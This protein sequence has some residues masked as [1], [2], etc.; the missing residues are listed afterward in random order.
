MKLTLQQVPLAYVNQTW[1][2]VEEFIQS[3]FAE[4]DPG[5]PLYNMHHVR[6]YVTSGTWLLVVVVDE[7]NKIHGALTISFYNQPLHRVALITAIGG[8]GISNRDT[9]SQLQSIVRQNGA[10]I[11]QGFG[12]PSIVRLWKRY[13][14]KPRNTLF[15]VLL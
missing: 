4:G 5:E 6:E 11:L 15:E 7:N 2:L 14:F 3:A 10:S 8:S 12:R 13:N 9:F 1:P